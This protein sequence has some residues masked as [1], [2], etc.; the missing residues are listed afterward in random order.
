MSLLWQK[1]GKKTQSCACT[2]ERWGAAGS[3]DSLD[4]VQLDFWS[5]LHQSSKDVKS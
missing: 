5:S 3:A 2:G 4:P 1:G